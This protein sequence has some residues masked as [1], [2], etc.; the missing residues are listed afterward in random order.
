MLK[1]HL[2]IAVDPENPANTQ[3]TTTC[4]SCRNSVVYTVTVEQWRKWMGGEL[5]QNVMPE[6][7]AEQR[8]RLISGTCG[9]CWQK[10]FGREEE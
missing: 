3:V 7:N 5:I 10:M 1:M 4:F 2:K 6:L 9:T 8:E